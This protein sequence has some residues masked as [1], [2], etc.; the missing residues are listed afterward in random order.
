MYKNGM[1]DSK[2]MVYP[3]M[4]WDKRKEI[5]TYKRLVSKS[6]GISL[7]EKFIKP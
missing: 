3:K 5:L 2:V 6:K 4:L 7:L 1:D